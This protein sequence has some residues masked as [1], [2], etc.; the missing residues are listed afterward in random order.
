M[1]IYLIFA[2]IGYVILFDLKN[3]SFINIRFFDKF[4]Y[5]NNK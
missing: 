3:F 1:K 5:M 2:Y 4:V